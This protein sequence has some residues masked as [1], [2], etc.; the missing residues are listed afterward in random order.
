DSIYQEFRTTT[1]L[2]ISLIALVSHRWE[3]K[4]RL[5]MGD[6]VTASDILEEVQANY[7]EK[8][9]DR[10]MPLFADAQYD[11]F[12]IMQRTEGQEWLARASGWIHRY[13]EELGRTEG[14]QAIA[15]MVAQA[16]RELIRNASGNSITVPVIEQGK[17]DIFERVVTQNVP[18]SRL[19]KELDQLLRSMLKVPSPYQKRALTMRTELDAGSDD[20]GDGESDVLSIDKVKTFVEAANLGNHHA[21]RR[22]WARAEEAFSKAVAIGNP[23][24]VQL[25]EAKDLVLRMQVMQANALLISGE[26][27]RC[28]TA[29]ERAWKA[30]P[31]LP[32]ASLAA[33]LA[34]RAAFGLQGEARDAET[35]S[36]TKT[37]LESVAKSIMDTWPAK[38][39]ADDARIVLGRASLTEAFLDPTAPDDAEFSNAIRIFDQVNELSERYPAALST[40]AMAHW[41]RYLLGKNA[42]EPDADQTSRRNSALDYAQ[43]AKDA[44]VRQNESLPADQRSAMPPAQFEAQFLLGEIAMEGGDASAAIEQ[45]RPLVDAVSADP[46]TARGQYTNAAMLT[47][48][49]AFLATDDVDGA[50]RAALVLIDSGADTPAM[51]RTLVQFAR[52]LDIQRKQASAGLIEASSDTEKDVAQKKLQRAA[53]MMAKIL[54]QLT[55]RRQLTTVD[56]LNLAELCTT[57]T[58]TGEAKAIYERL[59]AD[60]G[61]DPRAVTR[62]RAQL[63]GLLRIEKNFSEAFR[64]VSLLLEENEN[65]FEPRVERARILQ[66]WAA[67]ENN[68]KLFDDAATEWIRLRNQL[69]NLRGQKP[70][71]FFEVNYNAAVC[72][73]QQAIRTATTAPDRA[74]EK[75]TSARQLLQGT[76]I[77]N[78]ALDGPDRVARYHQQIR[79]IDDFLR[80]G[81]K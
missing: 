58:L 80:A 30:N 60:A 81:K 41:Q 53:D 72:L 34:M 5:E 29:M 78:K 66:D 13:E 24:K 46:D 35:R 70:P 28:L 59:I 10:L 55:S 7:S 76:L 47:S 3:A 22:E 12:L 6:Y 67:A 75:M 48:T 37:K 14:Y 8:L 65:A 71:E 61:T 49:R 15:W 21:Q 50:A 20:S 4:C 1:G 54:P 56:A 33:S 39:V 64:Q 23:D 43:R 27:S 38:P 9:S 18:K 62:A 26:Y 45:L 17:N 63:A 57:A 11:L 77:M 16:R 79:R 69:Q 74:R 19:T 44:A 32:S 31:T 42:Q 40:A 2:E 36:K 25:E 51:N 73:Y 52:Q 68:L